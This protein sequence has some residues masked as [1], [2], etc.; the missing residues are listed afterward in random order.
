MI[1]NNVERLTKW[2]NDRERETGL[3]DNQVAV[4]GKFSP[5]VISKL[6]SQGIIPGWDTCVKIA[7]VFHVN[8]VQVF[9]EAGLLPVPIDYPLEYQLSKDMFDQLKP[10]Q[11]V[12]LRVMVWHTIE[13]NKN[14]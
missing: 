12:M 2:L 3:S 5:A 10:D 6:R 11:K 1:Q 14:N 8:P 4:R 7:I 13:A 9:Y